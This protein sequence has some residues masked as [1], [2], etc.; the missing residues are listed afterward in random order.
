MEP[1]IPTLAEEDLPRG[2][3][4]DAERGGGPVAL[5]DVVRGGDHSGRAVRWLSALARESIPGSPPVLPLSL[6]EARDLLDELDR[7]AEEPGDL[8]ALL[9]LL[10]AEHEEPFPD[11][12]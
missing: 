10:P 2:A 11:A 5:S 9:Q 6:E 1:S 12:P 4:G 3:E 8:P 7:L